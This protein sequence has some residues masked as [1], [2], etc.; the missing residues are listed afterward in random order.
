MNCIL[1]KD[2]IK[3]FVR[4]QVAETLLK[5][6][7]VGWSP[8]SDDGRPNRRYKFFGRDKDKEQ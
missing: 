7:A 5:V 8:G 4:V 2:F 3:Y 6:S 1:Q